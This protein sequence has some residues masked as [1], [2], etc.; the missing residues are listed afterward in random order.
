MFTTGL[1]VGGLWPI[2]IV[3]RGTLLQHCQACM[4]DCDTPQHVPSDIHKCTKGMTAQTFCRQHPVSAPLGRLAAILQPKLGGSTELPRCVATMHVG[5][6]Q[7]AKCAIRPVAV[8]A[9][10]AEQTAATVKQQDILVLAVTS[11]GMLYEWAVSGLQTDSKPKSILQ[12]QHRLPC[13]VAQ[14]SSVS[15]PSSVNSI[16]SDYLDSRSLQDQ[17]LGDSLQ[18]WESIPK[19][20]AERQT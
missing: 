13:H 4:G 6:C 15:K 10:P 11:E 9:R 16:E 19:A 12:G 7:W 17:A 5:A 20:T 1:L 18:T 8:P 3:P 2:V 14:P